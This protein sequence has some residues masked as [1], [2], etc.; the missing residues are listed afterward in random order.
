MRPAS[1][2]TDR[3]RA[4]LRAYRTVQQ[5]GLTLSPRA[6]LR[7]LRLRGQLRRHLRRCMGCVMLAAGGFLVGS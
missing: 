1:T 6:A 2:W 5:V 7:Y 4:E 3:D